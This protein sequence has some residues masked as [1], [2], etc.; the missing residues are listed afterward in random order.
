MEPQGTAAA[1]PRVVLD[2]DVTVFFLDS[3]NKPTEVGD[4]GV[5]TYRVMAVY[6]PANPDDASEVETITLAEGDVVNIRCL[7]SRRRCLVSR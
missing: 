7:G 4:I 3:A 2:S 1:A 5:G 6:D